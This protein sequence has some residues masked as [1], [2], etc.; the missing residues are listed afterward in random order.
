MSGWDTALPDGPP[1]GVAMDNGRWPPT[2][3]VIETGADGERIPSTALKG[4][5]SGLVWTPHRAARRWNRGL[6]Y[7]LS[8][9]VDGGKS[10]L[11]TL[12][13][14]TKANFPDYDALR[15]VDVPRI[16]WRS[17]KDNSASVAG[18]ATGHAAFPCPALANRA[19]LAAEQA[20][21]ARTC[22]C[23]MWADFRVS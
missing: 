20:P 15:M 3:V 1:R 10:P 8:R 21:V 16:G 7:G 14:P 11:P 6:I 22:P 9:P 18:W 2:A 17:C 4:L 5:R 19:Y 13:R 12:S 23:A